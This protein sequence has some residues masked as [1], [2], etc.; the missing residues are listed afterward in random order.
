MMQIE[1]SVTINRPIE[2]VFAFV[3]N[4]DNNPRWQPEVI[5]H[6]ML[7]EGPMGLGSKMR[8]VSKFMGRRIEVN[9]DITEFVPNHKIAFHVMSGTLPYTIYYILD[10]EGDGT[11]FT[12]SAIMESNGWLKLAQP[13]MMMSG[14]RVIEGDLGRLKAL[15]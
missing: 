1:R 2:Q 5:E 10:P 15:L 11:R 8:H 13:L 7:T 4:P 3:A 14:A 9:I 6:T 12:Y